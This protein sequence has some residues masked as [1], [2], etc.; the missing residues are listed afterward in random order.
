MSVSFGW[1]PSRLDARSPLQN[2]GSGLQ[3]QDQEGPLTSRAQK[4]LE[5]LV[6]RLGL[7]SLDQHRIERGRN[8]NAPGLRRLGIAR[9]L[10]QQPVQ[11]CAMCV[12]LHKLGRAGDQAGEGVRHSWMPKHPLVA[13]LFR[14]QSREAVVE[15]LH[16][17][18]EF[19]AGD[20][21][22]PGHHLEGWRGADRRGH[23]GLGVQED[24]R[25]RRPGRIV[26]F[27]EHFCQKLDR[28]FDQA[29]QTLLGDGKP[30]GEQWVTQASG[31]LGKE[32]RI[33]GDA[34]QEGLELLSH[35]P[36]L[37]PANMIVEHLRTL[38]LGQGVNV[39]EN[40]ALLQQG[41]GAGF[42]VGPR[43]LPDVFA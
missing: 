34:T 3:H 5:G 23:P 35:W 43:G 36:R 40:L 31:G 15:M 28:M 10:G 42:Q 6:Q 22:Q 18:R 20:A 30:S 2:I 33:C 37:D 24:Q 17:E 38:R 25:D 32:G 26:E 12:E 13:V 8:A 4:R 39:H 14:N 21:H 16:R 41:E 1:L 9:H 11:L 7:Q 27:L 29:G 19:R